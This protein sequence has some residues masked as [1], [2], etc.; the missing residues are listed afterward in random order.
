[1]GLKCSLAE[2]KSP[3]QM[4]CNSGNC[5]IFA[6]SAL[7]FRPDASYAFLSVPQAG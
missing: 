2:L 7:W 5:R 4:I 1:M 3:C 6:F